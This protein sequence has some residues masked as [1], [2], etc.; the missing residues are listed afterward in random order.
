[1]IFARE[2]RVPIYHRITCLMA[3]DQ[4]RLSDLCDDLWIPEPI[5]LSPY[6]LVCCPFTG[7]LILLL[8]LVN[9]IQTGRIVWFLIDEGYVKPCAWCWNCGRVYFIMTEKRSF[10][11]SY[12]IS[13]LWPYKQLGPH[14]STSW[15][16]RGRLHFIIC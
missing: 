16:F 15:L 5:K 2:M 8:S 10:K 11:L 4:G 6:R 1:M 12:L 9:I 7:W 3:K 13:T 14:R